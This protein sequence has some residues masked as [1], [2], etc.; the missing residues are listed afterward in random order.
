M[1]SNSTALDLRDRLQGVLIGTAVGDALGLPAEGLSKPRIARRW[2]GE[3][4]HRLLFGRGMISDDTEH[5][6][7]VAQA[8]LRHPA[9]VDGFRRALAW[10]LRWW[11]LSLPAGIG[12]ATLR[13]ILKLWLGWPAHR[14]G[15]FSAGNGPAMRAGI[16]GGYFYDDPARRKA[17][18]TAST[19]VTHTDPKALIGSLAVATVVAL[20]VGQGNAEGLHTADLLS[21]LAVLGGE[22]DGQW[23]DLVR[24]MRT[25]LQRGDDVA[26][27]AAVLGLEKAVS[28]YVYHTVPVAIYACLRHRGAFERALTAALDLGGDTDTVGAIVGAMAAAS[29]GRRGIPRGWGERHFGLA[30]NAGAPR[31]R[32][33]STRAA[34]TRGASAR[35]SSLFLACG[36]ATQSGL[37]RRSTFPR[38][39]A[40]GSAVAFAGGSILPACFAVSWGDTRWSTIDAPAPL[41]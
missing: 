13:A 38:I 21:Q 35:C 5:T 28:G 18:V 27:F 41:V 33:R 19:L 30:T 14:S 6:L 29:V 37:S 1:R 40:P 25:A 16:I 3:W 10:K 20:E 11:L 39:Q 36:S 7:F 24:H 2:R 31:E 23:Q 8:L 12:F 4:R 22:D 9:D 32:R 15:V 17:F 34:A 26:R